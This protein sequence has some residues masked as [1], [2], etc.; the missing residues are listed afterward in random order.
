MALMEEAAA[1]TE[2]LIKHR[3]TVVQMKGFGDSSVDLELLVWINDPMNGL[4][5]I[6]SEILLGVWDKFREHGVELPFPQRDLHIRSAV[7]L[8]LAPQMAN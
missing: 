3:P 4:A 7:P 2:R 6:K 5:N 1:E 8:E